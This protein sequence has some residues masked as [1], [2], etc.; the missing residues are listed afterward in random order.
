LRLDE[1]QT[2]TLKDILSL[3]DAEAILKY[4]PGIEAG[5]VGGMVEVGR[6][7]AFA[8]KREVGASSSLSRF[9]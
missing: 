7:D 4:F 8:D 2:Y 3:R 1:E 9:R 5:D 6:G